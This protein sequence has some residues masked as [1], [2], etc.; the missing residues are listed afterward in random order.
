MLTVENACL[1][2]QREIVFDHLNLEVPAGRWVVIVGPSG[3]GKTSLLRFIAGFEPGGRIL[4]K[5]QADFNTA[6]MAQ[7]DALLPWLT[8]L[9]NVMLQQRLQGGVK[10]LA[11][12][13]ELLEAVGLSA[14]QTALPYMLSGGMRQR[15]A[16]A[17]ILIQE[18]DL[19]LMDEPFSA[20]DALTR[21]EMQKLSA[22]LLREA[23]KTVVM[24]THDPWEALRLA[25]EIKV[26][27]GRPAHFVKTLHVNERDDATLLLQYHELMAA[28]QVNL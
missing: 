22:K 6:Y 13:Q 14:Y 25:D 18:A 19:V 27:Q 15:V 26:L 1:L 3:V 9:E 16:L 17:R 10:P 11:R 21:L 5:G 20:L 4:W 7:D 23:S 12:A 8:V 28:L 2:Y 24:I